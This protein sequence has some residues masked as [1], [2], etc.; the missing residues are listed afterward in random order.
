MMIGH[1]NRPSNVNGNVDRVECFHV[2]AKDYMAKFPSTKYLK[3]VFTSTSVKYLAVIHQE[4]THIIST[5]T[6]DDRHDN[7]SS[8]VNGNVDGEILE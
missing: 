5:T 1:D 2:I 8:Y 7:R 4:R 3:M 6:N